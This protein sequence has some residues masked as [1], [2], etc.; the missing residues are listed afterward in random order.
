M[1]RKQQNKETLDTNI[2]MLNIL[3]N[4]NFLS[5]KVGVLPLTWSERS[6]NKNIQ[7]IEVS[8]RINVRNYETE[9]KKKKKK[10]WQLEIFRT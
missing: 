10:Q 4:T 1:I 9:E 3:L 8:P 2:S 6:F 7:I 5:S